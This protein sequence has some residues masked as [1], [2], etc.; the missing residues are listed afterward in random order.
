MMALALIAATLLDGRLLRG[1]GL[2]V[3]KVGRG[4]TSST[5]DIRIAPTFAAETGRSG[6]VLARLL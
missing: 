1:P 3:P 6:H 4:T 2:G 5:A